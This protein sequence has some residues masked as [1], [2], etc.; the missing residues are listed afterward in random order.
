MEEEPEN[1]P[2]TDEG[3]RQKEED[4]TQPIDENK[5]TTIRTSLIEIKGNAEKE[6]GQIT[7]AIL[8]SILAH[9]RWKRNYNRRNVHG[10]EETFVYSEILG[11]VYDRKGNMVLSR[12][13]TQYPE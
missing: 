5:S 9:W 6:N 3:K 13:T 11:L 1:E 4:L 2:P 7:T 12:R 10:P 8:Q